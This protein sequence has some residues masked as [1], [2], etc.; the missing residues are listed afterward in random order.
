MKKEKTNYFTVAVYST[1]IKRLKEKSQKVLLDNQKIKVS[2]GRVNVRQNF[3]SFNKLQHKTQ[4]LI[5]SEDLSIPDLRFDTQAMWIL[6]PNEYRKILDEKKFN[7]EGSLHAVVH[8]LIHMVPILAQID[9]Y[10]I[11]GTFIEE[12]QEFNQTIIYIFDAFRDGVGIAERVYEKINELLLM[13]RDLI[14]S[15]PCTSKK[16]CPA[17]IM[18][19]NCVQM[20]DPLDKKGALA[21][22]EL[23]IKGETEVKASKQLNT[24]P[25]SEQ[26]VFDSTTKPPEKCPEC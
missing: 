9:R 1:E 19:T 24:P 11:D 6:I 12:D 7:I 20:N 26:E 8:A 25:K 14:K 13:T 3:Y 4:K 5:G 23:L 22:L 18:A 15:C 17:C 21:L 2:H 10:D 16:G